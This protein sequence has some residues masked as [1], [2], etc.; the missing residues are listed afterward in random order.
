M[1]KKFNNYFLLEISRGIKVM[2]EGKEYL[3]YLLNKAISTPK[4]DVIDFKALRTLLAASIGQVSD[5]EAA[6]LAK[7][8]EKQQKIRK[9]L[10]RLGNEKMVVSIVE[11]DEGICDS[12]DSVSLQLTKM[13]GERSVHNIPPSNQKDQISAGKLMN[14][15]S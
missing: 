15:K 12:T 6:N 2:A 10:K 3:W 1:R 14:D 13:S 11:P 8:K 9:D 7:M 5:D 4:A